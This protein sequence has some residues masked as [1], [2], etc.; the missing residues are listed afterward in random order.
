MGH[1]NFI[2]GTVSLVGSDRI[3]RIET[4]TAA[5]PCRIPAGIQPGQKAL[6]ALRYEKVELAPE[7]PGDPHAISGVVLSRSYMGAMVRYEVQT[8]MNLVLV[9][10]IA[11][12]GLVF[13][14]AIG[15]RVTVRWSP[16]APAILA[17]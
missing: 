3:G 9:A 17:N 4:E 7:K 14:P 12:P 5:L 8:S 10:D 6:F 16:D 15:D 11:N 13:S 1:S 2:E